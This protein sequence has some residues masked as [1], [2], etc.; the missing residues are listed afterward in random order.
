M[1]AYLTVAE[2][3]TYFSTRLYTKEWVDATTQEKLAALTMAQAAVDA[4]PYIGIRASVVLA[5]TYGY[6]ST[7]VNAFPRYYEVRRDPFYGTGPAFETIPVTDLIVPQVVKDAVCEEALA[8]LRFGDSE[9]VRLQGQGV[10]SA[11]R[12]DLHEVYAPRSGLLSP[13]ARALLRPW[14]MGVVPLT[15]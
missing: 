11:S 8:L 15:T 9:R 13:E 14:M 1:S 5:P 6:P 3:A 10:T 7:D 2:A 4:Q 12:G